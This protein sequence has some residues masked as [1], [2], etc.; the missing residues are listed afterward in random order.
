ML[1]MSIRRN[2]VENGTPESAEGRFP[3]GRS[4]WFA[5]RENATSPA[6]GTGQ[7]RP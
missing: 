6:S 2:L 3:T 7:R 4:L 1:V 5:W